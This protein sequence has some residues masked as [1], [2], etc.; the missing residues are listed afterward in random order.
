MKL[1]EHFTERVGITDGDVNMLRM[2][3][4]I[5]FAIL[6]HKKGQ[7]DNKMD[8]KVL[9]TSKYTL[10]IPLNKIVHHRYGQMEFVCPFVKYEF[11]YDYTY[12]VVQGK[13]VG[14]TFT[15]SDAMGCLLI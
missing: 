3:I 10:P 9:D 7:R 6:I 4:F 8:C 2:Q 12:M 15:Y 1:K 11:A 13:K 14:N 5:A